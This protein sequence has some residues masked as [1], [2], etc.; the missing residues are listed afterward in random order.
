MF[1]LRSLTREKLDGLVAAQNNLGF[2]SIV[3]SA[4]RLHDASMGIGQAAGACAAASLKRAVQP[5]EIPFNREYLIGLQYAIVSK[6]DNGQRQISVSRPK[7]KL[8]GSRKRELK[9]KCGTEN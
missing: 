8:A 4:V 9:S 2:S 6:L 7:H 1:P 5:R 3:S